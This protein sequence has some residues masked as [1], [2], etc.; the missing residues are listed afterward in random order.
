MKFRISL[1]KRGLSTAVTSAILL[2]AVTVMGTMLVSWSNMN[3]T[4]HQQDLDASFSDN[5]NRINEELLLGNI[6]FG[7]TP[8]NNINI[9]M[10]NVGTVGLNVTEIEIKDYST[11]STK[12]LFSYSN[13]GLVP[14]GEFS[15]NETFAWDVDTS[16]EVII[17]TERGSAFRTQVTAP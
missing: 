9:T 4:R 14:R 12:K 13:T 3:L 16:Y 8:S 17:T 15:V 2:A 10:N 11:G 5:L 1:S 7:N 6:W